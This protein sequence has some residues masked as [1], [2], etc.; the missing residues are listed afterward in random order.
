MYRIALLV[1]VTLFSQAALAAPSNYLD[2]G[3]LTAQESEAL[4][5]Y[6][7]GAGEAYG[8]ANVNLKSRGQ[9][10]LFC[11]PQKLKLNGNNYEKIYKDE[12]DKNRLAYTPIINQLGVGSLSLVGLVLLNG[13]KSTF[14]CDR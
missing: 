3:S 11:V 8:W 12:I 14:P 4:A 10:P 2:Y 6:V 5:V 1:V 13:L 7:T 9:A